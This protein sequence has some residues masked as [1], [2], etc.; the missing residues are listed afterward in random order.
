MGGRLVDV[1]INS[2]QIKDLIYTIRGKQVMLDGDLAILYELSTGRLN[3][4]VKRNI[5]RFPERF[6]F[7]L[8][9]EEYKVLISQFV[10]SK[11]GEMSGGRQI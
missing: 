6:T 10:M 1:E 2:N 11:N 7:R 9:S 8:T 4:Q 3:E 5:K